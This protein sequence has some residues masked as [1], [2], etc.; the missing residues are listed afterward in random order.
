MDECT[1]G[2]AECSAN[3]T[4]TNTIGSYSCVCKSGFSGDGKT[5]TPTGKKC[6]EQWPVNKLSG[7]VEECVRVIWLESVKESC[8]L[9]EGCVRVIW[10]KGVSEWSIWLESVKESSCGLVEVYGE[11]SWF[12]WRVYRSRV[13][14]LNGVGEELGAFGEGCVG[15]RWFGWRLYSN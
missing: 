6:H 4:C 2:F 10:L 9:V 1:N 15:V 14:C 8:G 11:V 7:L 13:I 3:A 5:C 12:G